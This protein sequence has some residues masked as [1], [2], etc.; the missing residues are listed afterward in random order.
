M[1]WHLNNSLPWICG[2]YNTLHTHAPHL[3]VLLLIFVA[4]VTRGLLRVVDLG[5][6]QDKEMGVPLL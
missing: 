3:P 5:V 6:R 4:L 1:Y 2:L